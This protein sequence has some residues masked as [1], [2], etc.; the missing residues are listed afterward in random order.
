MKNTGPIGRSLI[1]A[2]IAACFLSLL[3]NT[4]SDAQ[5]MPDPGTPNTDDYVQAPEK[6]P[7]AGDE[8]AFYTGVFYYKVRVRVRY[9]EPYEKRRDFEEDVP[10]YNYDT[11]TGEKQ[12]GN[13]KED[14]QV[15]GNAVQGGDEV[16]YRI[17]LR[18]AQVA[19][20]HSRSRTGNHLRHPGI[21]SESEFGPKAIRAGYA[22]R[23]A[24]VACAHEHPAT[25]S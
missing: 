15:C 10:R 9:L 19:H 6:D 16:H 24:A 4:A 3:G 17:A 23:T 12:P 2:G 11:K 25:G 8:Q 14:N 13:R 22:T 1:L 18:H 20:G 5:T 7:T 21:S